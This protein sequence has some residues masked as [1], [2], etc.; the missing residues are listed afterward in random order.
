MA[1]AEGEDEEVVELLDSDEDEAAPEAI[2]VETYLLGP[3]QVG[4]VSIKQEEPQ[5][6]TA[7]ATDA[8]SRKR[9]SESRPREPEPSAKRARSSAP[10]SPPTEGG[11]GAAGGSAGLET[12]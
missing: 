12:R 9:G 6:A 3:L 1:L 7:A 10:V 5:A 2:D 4:R 11:G 8:S